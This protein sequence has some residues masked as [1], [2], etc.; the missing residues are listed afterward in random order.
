MRWPFRR[1]SSAGDP[2]GPEQVSNAQPEPQAPEVQA[3]AAPGWRDLPGIE[4]ALG[5]MPTVTDTGF[6]RSLPT[7]WHT[8][9]ALGALG[10]DV[11]T[12]VPGGLVSGVA[13]TV[14]PL[15]T[16]PADLVWRTPDISGLS[17]P[18]AVAPQ[19]A[20][21]VGTALASTAAPQALTA[22][23]PAAAGRTATSSASPGSNPAG[24]AARQYQISAATPE[25]VPASLAPV[26]PQSPVS[27][28]TS[29]SPS[30]ASLD[31]AQ[32]RQAPQDAGL[33]VEARDPRPVPADVTDGQAAA[34]PVPG[35]TI[36]PESET[37][38]SPPSTS[39]TGPGAL[40]TPREARPGPDPLGSTP[41]VAPLVSRTAVSRITA[42][43]LTGAA[44]TVGPVPE[45]PPMPTP[46]PAPGVPTTPTAGPSDLSGPRTQPESGSELG[47]V[48]VSSSIRDSS[49]TPDAL[50]PAAGT[51]SMPSGP[52]STPA[53]A[54]MPAG[55]GALPTDLASLM[56]EA[57]PT[58]PGPAPIA[59]PTTSRVAPLVSATRFA[60]ATEP[61][62]ILQAPTA[63]V[64]QPVRA[65]ESIVG[66]FAG[67]FANA[68]SV[69][70]PSVN[71]PLIN[72]PSI[73]MP[74]ANTPFGGAGSVNAPSAST[75]GALAQAAS[76]AAASPSALAAPSSRS[77]VQQA[78]R[79]TSAAVAPVMN[80]ISGGG[81]PHQSLASQA[82]AAA[83]AATSASAS[84]AANDHAALDTLARQLYGR[85]SRHLAGELLIDRERAQFLTDLT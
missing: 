82:L 67:A 66:S 36:G 22:T 25:A 1:P 79:E 13:R 85:F 56:S 75:I 6:S 30:N 5:A 34:P 18:A 53:S 55:E 28:Q 81:S 62:N 20:G 27:L 26:S 8:P 71:A 70:T 84:T 50:E 15:D 69:N 72:T 38:E 31:A 12:D 45:Q 21:L 74:P 78:V 73:N 42:Q 58:H 32:T 65:T 76:Q 4:P 37:L 52:G 57:T 7:R 39:T 64:D 80:A 40:L 47:S 29:V 35:V 59:P 43:P 41:A 10:H 17:A 68:P 33:A 19:G 61:I 54:P 49:T 51:T 14:D 46:A 83:S 48:A 77:T 44:T 60:A 63:P 2:A 9:P 23:R 11:R 16:R 3:A 24:S